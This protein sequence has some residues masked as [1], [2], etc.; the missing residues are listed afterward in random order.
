MQGPGLGQASIEHGGVKHVCEYSTPPPT[1]W[2]SGQ[3]FTINLKNPH[4]PGA[5]VE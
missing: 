2:V 4:I 3:A 1:S 5:I